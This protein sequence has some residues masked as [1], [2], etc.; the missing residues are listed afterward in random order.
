MITSRSEQALQRIVAYLS[1]A[2]IE[3]TTDVETRVL[4]LITEALASNPEAL[5]P[6][7]MRMLPRYFELP[8]QPGLLKSPPIHRGSLGYGAY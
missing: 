1:L 3:V 7:C 2:G 8:P 6:A 4:A 5:L